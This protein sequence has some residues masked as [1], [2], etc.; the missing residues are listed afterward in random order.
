MRTPRII[1]VILLA[2]AVPMLAVQQRS[3]ASD[4]SLRTSK[5]VGVVIDP[6]GARIP[7]AA[8]RIENA[9]ARR[10]AYTDDEG[11]FEVELPAG[12]YRITIEAEG[13]QKVELA[14][15]RVRPDRRESLEVSMK[16]K[17][18]ESTLK[19]E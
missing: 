5:I 16:V 19:I 15:F 17:P 13:F 2:L 18:P 11:S 9:D 3:S 1:A 4:G 6:N 8:V 12:A 7:F 14:S 10:E